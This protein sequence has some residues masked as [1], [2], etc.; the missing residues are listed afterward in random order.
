LKFLY[1]DEAQEVIAKHFYRPIKDEVRDRHAAALPPIDLFPVT[2]VARNWDD[3]QERF[4]AEGGVFDE[5]YS[6]PAR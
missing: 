6:G 5:I 3:A 4:F 1:T 2:T